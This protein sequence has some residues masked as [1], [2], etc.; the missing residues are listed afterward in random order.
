MAKKH[1]AAEV[2]EILADFVNS[3]YQSDQKDLAAEILCQHRTLQQ[4]IF[5]VFMLTIKAWSEL[6]EH[7]YDAR[8]GYT[9]ETSKDIMAALKDKWFGRTPLI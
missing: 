9:V 2:A 5:N 8:N 3:S 7:H 4:S 1:T 6:P